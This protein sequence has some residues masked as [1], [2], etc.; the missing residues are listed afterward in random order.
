[1]KTLKSIV[2]NYYYYFTFKYL[3]QILIFLIKIII[4][5]PKINKFKIKKSEERILSIISD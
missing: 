3:K 2:I 5:Q 1:M 4:K